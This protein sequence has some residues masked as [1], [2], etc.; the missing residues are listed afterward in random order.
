[1][2]KNTLS[3]LIFSS[4]CATSVLASQMVYTP[5]NPSFGGNPFNGSVLL[6]EANANNHYVSPTPVSTIN[7]SSTTDSFLA[8]AILSSLSSNVINTILNSRSGDSG[9]GSLGTNQFTFQ[10]V[11]GYISGTIFDSSSG[12]TTPFSGLHDNSNSS[13]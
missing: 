8:N 6:N 5:A 2:I 4:L 10:N 7:P 1:M 13:R 3:V 9:S 11:G 12:T